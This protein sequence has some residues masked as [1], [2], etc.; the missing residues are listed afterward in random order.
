MYCP[1]CGIKIN[2]EI[3]CPV[4]GA[5]LMALQEL[6]EKN[7]RDIFIIFIADFIVIGIMYYFFKEAAFFI[8]F[9]IIIGTLLINFLS[10]KTSGNASQVGKC[11]P[12]CYNMYLNGNYCIKCGYHLDKILGFS[13][14]TGYDLEIYSEF[15][16]I[17]KYMLI[18]GERA[19]IC[20]SKYRVKDIRNLRVSNKCGYWI[21]R[22]P[23]LIFDYDPQ[24][25]QVE[26]KP[27]SKYTFKI[28]ILKKLAPQ[29]KSVIN[30][31]LFEKA[32]SNDP[33]PVDGTPLHMDY[34]QKPKSG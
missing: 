34:N 21:S 8:G 31:P 4:C 20:T 28:A 11:C 30:E 9:V 23:C 7:K 14:W 29:I 6:K 22:M 16:K 24:H 12:N 27:K 18:K 3:I 13:T 15:F 33:Y 17:S 2:D 26:G 10:N 1:S 32:R 19:Y 25:V 5:D